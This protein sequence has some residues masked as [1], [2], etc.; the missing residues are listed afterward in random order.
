HGLDRDAR[1]DRDRKDPEQ[2]GDEARSDDPA[3]GCATR[4][5]GDHD[6][7]RCA[8][9]RA[10]GESAS[11]TTR[12]VRVMFS[13][14]KASAIV[15]ISTARKTAIGSV[16]L[17]GLMSVVLSATLRLRIWMRSLGPTPLASCS[18]ST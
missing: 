8:C 3:T 13:S 2:A 9:G 16:L 11:E 5:A 1:D 14:A 6:A 4:G 17:R 12:T 18:A 7:A 15:A 10:D